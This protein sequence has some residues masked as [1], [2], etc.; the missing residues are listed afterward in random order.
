VATG[1]GGDEACTTI[2]CANEQQASNAATAQGGGAGSSGSDMAAAD[3]FGDLGSGM[4]PLQDDQVCASVGA[5]A[6][7]R[8]I[9]VVI[10]LDRSISMLASVDASV[11]GAPSRWEAVNSALG[12]FVNSAQAADAR[13][14]LQFLGLMNQDDCEVGKYAVPA[15]AVAPLT[16]NRTA[17][18]DVLGK[19]R[20]G[21]LTPAAP[22]IEGSLRYALS[23]AQR[24]EN[25]DIPTVLV[26]ASDG[27]P[28][29]C[30]PI[31]PDG[32]RTVSFGQIL[33]I[34]KSYSQPADATQPVIR[35]HLVGTQELASNASSLAQAGGGEAFLVGNDAGSGVDLEVKF[36]EALLRIVVKP[37][38]CEWDLP[39]ATEDGQAIDFEQ[40]RARFTASSSG[41]VSEYPRARD[42]TTCGLNKAWYYDD[43]LAPKKL[44]FCPDT[45][46][47]LGAGEL[48]LDF[49]CSE[50]RI[51][52]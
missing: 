34:L 41:T 52:R 21:S 35:T 28:T 10:L 25:A 18:L 39:Q 13:V 22:A 24:P 44:V 40:V 26:L 43:P 17:L 42:L 15:V 49:G 4:G 51:V 48:K 8:P 29:E 23:V 19:T 16:S 9:N 46:R 11:P 5:T 27:L 32:L 7:T 47:S 30:G 14:G 2:G 20:P 3:V 37:L 38:A 31:G 50:G 12:S 33:D 6:P 1:C 36:L 45:C